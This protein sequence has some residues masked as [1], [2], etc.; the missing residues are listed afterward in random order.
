MFGTKVRIYDYEKEQCKVGDV[1]LFNFKITGKIPSLISL[2][3]KFVEY[4]VTTK[5]KFEIEDT[6]YN[7]K[8][9]F[10]VQ[11]VVTQNPLPFL[12]VF[13]LIV[14][15]SSTLLMILGMQLT[16]VEKIVTVTAQ[17]AVPYAV[18]AF[19]VYSGIKLFTKG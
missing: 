6:Y 1:Y 2:K 16:K 9:Q 19:I 4:C 17:S 14:A 12:V 8:G 18:L 7:E 15:G 11:A 3:E 13:G 10:V 5:D